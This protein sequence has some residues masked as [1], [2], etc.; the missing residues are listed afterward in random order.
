MQV[1]ISLSCGTDLNMPLTIVAHSE[2][3]HGLEKKKKRILRFF[4][5]MIIVRELFIIKYKLFLCIVSQEAELLGQ[6]WPYG[7][8]RLTV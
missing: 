1:E 3:P 7:D 2:P 6:K 4:N 8:R 5:L